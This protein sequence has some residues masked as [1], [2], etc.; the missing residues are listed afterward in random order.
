MKKEYTNNDIERFFEAGKSLE[1]IID[2]NKVHQIINSPTAKAR[3]RGNKF[4]P[5][6]FIIMTSITAIIISAILFWPVKNTPTT[7]IENTYTPLKQQVTPQANTTQSEESSAAQF[8]DNEEAEN[9]VEP[10][11][12]PTAMANQS[13]TETEALNESP[14]LLHEELIHSPEIE[15]T[16]TYAGIDPDNIDTQKGSIMQVIADQKLLEKLGFTFKDNCVYYQNQSDKSA[17][18]AYSFVYREIDK[19][20]TTY[21]IGLSGVFTTDSVGFT[22]NAYFPVAQTYVSGHLNSSIYNFYL[23]IESAADTLF[24]VF[25]PNGLINHDANDF[26]LWFHVNREFFDLLPESFSGM[27]AEFE[28]RKRIKRAFPEIQLVDYKQPS[29]IDPSR[30][31]ELTVDELFGMGFSQTENSTMA[32]DEDGNPTLTPA[33]AFCDSGDKPTLKYEIGKP[34]TRVQHY[35]NINEAPLVFVTRTNGDILFTNNSKNNI[36]NIVPIIVHQEKFPDILQSDLLFWFLPSEYLFGR[37]P[38][39]IAHDLKE[40]YNYIVAENKSE[41]VKP[42][43]NFYEECRNTLL[44]SN[45]RVYPN[46]ANQN[47]SVSF[48]LPKAIEGRISLLDLQGRERLILLEKTSISKGFQQ[49][50]LDLSGIS[51]GIYLLTLFSDS[52]VQTQRLV[53]QR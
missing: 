31:I 45:F 10:I 52:G 12:E 17:T 28:K 49:F 18:Q 22:Q 50:D 38:E 40:E 21:T 16:N 47:A 19:T 24:P 6:N 3:L 46:P 53:V 2:N 9:E 35:S 11:A 32:L 1:P 37:L 34:G 39:H 15:N 48:E 26:V 42:E 30:F 51:E 27:N 25:I 33:L 44:I 29:I 20:T 23:E 14:Q 5:L 43:C 4:K 8:A 41:L 36:E 13:A 7:T